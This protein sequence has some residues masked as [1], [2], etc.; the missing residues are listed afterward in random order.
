MKL[1]HL[2]DL[3][4]AGAVLHLSFEKRL[5]WTLNDGIKA[6]RIG[7]RT[8]QAAIKRGTIVGAGDSLFAE[9]PSQTWHAT[10]KD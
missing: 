9:F 3:L 7:S 5:S 10:P 2:L 6:T 1:G 8:A 4:R